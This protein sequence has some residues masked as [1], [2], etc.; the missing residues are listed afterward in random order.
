VKELETP[1]L[2]IYLPKG[3]KTTWLRKVTKMIWMINP[4]GKGGKEF[5]KASRTTIRS[6]SIS[7]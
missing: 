7:C 4:D 5:L 3:I 1:L 6:I 2:L